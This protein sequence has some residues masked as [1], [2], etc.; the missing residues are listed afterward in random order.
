[1][2]CILPLCNQSF[3]Y[4]RVVRHWSRLLREAV[5]APSLEVVKARLDGWGLVL[6]DLVGGIPAYGKGVGVR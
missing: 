6:P 1:M 3:R 4:V 2:A 5:D